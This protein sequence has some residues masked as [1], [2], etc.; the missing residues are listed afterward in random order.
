MA[1]MIDGKPHMTIAEA[2]DFM[3]CTDGWVRHLLRTNKLR[4]KR[5]GQRLWLVSQE[6][7]IEARDGLTTRS[8]GKKHLAARPAAARKPKKKPAAPRK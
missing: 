3:G 4:G 7:A 5:I 8:A 6:S 1:E 2:V